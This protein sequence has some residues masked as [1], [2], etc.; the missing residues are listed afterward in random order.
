MP[1]IGKLLKKTTEITFK[2]NANKGK[3]YKDQLVTLE[4][5]LIKAKSTNFGLHHNFQEVINETDS[6]VCFQRHVPITEYDAFYDAWLK[7]TIQGKKD[8]TW[9]GKVKY[10]ALSSGTTGSPSK[11][12]PVSEDMIRSFQKTSIRQISTL[13]ELDLPASFYNACVLA[14]GG[15]TKLT[16]KSTHIEGDLSGILKKNTSFLLNPFTKPENRISSI[17]DWNKK[18]DKLVEKAP[19]WNISL[20]AGV[21][22]WCILLM[23]RIVEHYKVDSIHEI[24]PNFQVYVHGGVFMQPYIPRLEKITGKKVHLLDTYLASEGYF[25]YQVSP[26]K[27]GMKLLLNNGIFYEFVPF[28]NEFFDEDGVLKDVYKAYTLSEVTAGVDYAM[29]ISTNAGLW[30]YMI[31]DLVQFLDVEERLFKISGRIKQF[32][33][34][35]GEHLSMDNINTAI[36]KVT[37]EQKLEISEFCLFPEIAEQRHAW[38]IG[39][40]GAITEEKLMDLIDT[41]LKVLNDDY[42]GVRKVSLKQPVLKIVPLNSF[43]EFMESIGKIGSQNKVPRVMNKNQSDLWWEFLKNK[44]LL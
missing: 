22:S 6:V 25:G 9:C 13:H 24:W 32:L 27:E 40:E 43:Y 23:E 42:A 26:E 20:V 1:I 16:K 11:R 34:L 2:R 5:L 15:S 38:F 41:E 18:L 44:N 19:D 36:Q 10:F 35:C 33:S 8:H 7:D 37:Q 4:K 17:R 14:V 3:E 29:V 31:G 28:N 39:T 21:P 12:I 30:R